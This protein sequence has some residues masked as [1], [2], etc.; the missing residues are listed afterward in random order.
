P[1]SPQNP[2]KNG[3]INMSIDK[4]YSLRAVLK[5]LGVIQ[6]RMA[7]RAVADDIDE[8]GLAGPQCTFEGR[9][10]LLRPLDVLTVTIH[11]LEHPVVALVRQYLERIGPTLHEWDFFEAR[12]PRTVVQKSRDDR[13]AIAARSFEVEAADA[14]TT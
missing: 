12:P 10:K 9:A 3:G 4:Y 8:R 7:Y 6:G 2:T 13:Q 11:K 14:E 1:H 5:S